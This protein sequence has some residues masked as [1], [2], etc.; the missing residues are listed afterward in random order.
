MPKI[1][2]DKYIENSQIAWT[3]SRNSSRNL[4]SNFRGIGWKFAKQNYNSEGN[5]QNSVVLFISERIIAWVLENVLSLYLGLN[6]G[7]IHWRITEWTPGYYWEICEI[8][9]VGMPDNHNKVSGVP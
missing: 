5:P 6:P 2:L 4:W 8:I 9:F 3:I 7:E 1:I